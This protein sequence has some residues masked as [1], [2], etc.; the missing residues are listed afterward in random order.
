MIAPAPLL[1]TTWKK[2]RPTPGRP[3][4]FGQP[5]GSGW[6]LQSNWMV[7]L[8]SPGVPDSAWH[9]GPCCDGTD[10]S[11]QTTSIAPFGPIELLAAAA[12][13]TPMKP[14][15]GKLSGQLVILPPPRCAA[16]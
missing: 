14:A 13:T 5:V 8:P 1:Q 11:S 3:F 7:T 9:G 2:L 15:T 4:G 6:L 10:A 12:P 16:T